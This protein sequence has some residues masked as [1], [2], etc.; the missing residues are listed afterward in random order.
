[1][2]LLAQNH[3]AALYWYRGEYWIV[4]SDPAAPMTR[5]APP[6]ERERGAQFCAE[7]LRFRR[8]YVLDVVIAKFANLCGAP[9]FRPPCPLFLT[10]A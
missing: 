4:P 6:E 3:A 10:Q 9:S 7:S 2:F 1:M 8:A 5:V